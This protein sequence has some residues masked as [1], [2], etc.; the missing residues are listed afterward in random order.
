MGG[1][2]RRQVRRGQK[3]SEEALCSAPGRALRSEKPI[4]EGEYAQVHL[5]G[6]REGRGRLRLVRVGEQRA[7]PPVT[8][9]L[10]GRAWKV[11]GRPR[12]ASGRPWKGQ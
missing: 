2:Q 9:K 8:E 10:R 12:E 3:K 7:Q 6:E 11:S 1:G 4:E 5:E